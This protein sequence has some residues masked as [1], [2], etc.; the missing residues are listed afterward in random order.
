MQI[1][2]KTPTNE[3]KGTAQLADEVFGV[4]FR[5]GLVHQ[6]VQATLAGQRTGNHDT[7]TRGEVAGG[8]RKPWRQK[9]TGR[10][11]AGTIR[12]PLWRGGGT[13]F[14]PTPRSYAQ[15]VN[16][17][18]RQGALRSMLSEL[19]RR[20]ELLVVEDLG[21]KEGKTRELAST[22]KALEAE[23]ALV[24][25]PSGDEAVARAGGNLPR[26][27]VMPSNQ[28]GALA[29]VSHAKVVTTES[30]LRELEERLS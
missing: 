7:K 5:E 24:I 10:A 21:V 2:V 23:D 14:G 9:G 18:M 8:G 29:L 15:K 16:K 28:V 3:D 25:T 1:P 22:L 20:E 4:P 17:K 30:A 27:A 11:R 6:V 19:A 26:V 12:S 13:V